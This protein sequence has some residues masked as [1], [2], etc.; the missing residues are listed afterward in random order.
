[1]SRAS[2][3]G[4]RVGPAERALLGAPR[5]AEEDLGIA[6]APAMAGRRAGGTRRGCGYAGV[7]AVQAVLIQWAT[8]RPEPSSSGSFTRGVRVQ[9]SVRLGVSSGLPAASGGRATDRRPAD[10]HRMRAGQGDHLSRQVR[11][12]N[13]D[14]GRVQPVERRVHHLSERS[15]RKH[16]V[17]VSRDADGGV[18]DLAPGP[19]RGEEL[20]RW[21]FFQEVHFTLHASWFLRFLHPLHCRH[22]AVVTASRRSA[23]A[24]ASLR[25]PGPGALLR[26]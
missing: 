20:V 5:G 25:S 23:P 10:Q 24:C 3:S 1:M 7:R 6:M 19:R 21:S 22:R 16:S 12:R 11:R 15:D 13:E 14:G 8:P 17:R 26:L 2:A 4:C 9:L 18:P